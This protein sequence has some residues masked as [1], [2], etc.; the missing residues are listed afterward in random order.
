M[1]K[2]VDIKIRAKYRDMLKE[3]FDTWLLSPFYSHNLSKIYSVK[4]FADNGGWS[5][6]G[7]VC[8]TGF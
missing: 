5:A 7:M 4:D 8:C 1:D 6:V 3:Y 2:F